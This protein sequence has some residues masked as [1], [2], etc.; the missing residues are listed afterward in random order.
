[1]T[2]R[3]FMDAAES[4]TPSQLLR[5]Q[6]A[7]EPLSLHARDCAACGLW[8]ES[9][10]NLGSA[11]HTLSASTEQRGAGPRVEQAVLQAFR[12]Q[13]FAPKVVAMPVRTP[14]GLW[15]LSRVLEFGAYAAVA[16]ALIVGLFLGAR[17]L[18]DKQNSS[19]TEQA[20]TTSAPQSK[21]QELT[22]AKVGGE[23][24]EQAAKPTKTTGHPSRG[25]DGE[26]GGGGRGQSNIGWQRSG[27]ICCADALRSADLLGRRAS[28]PHGVAR[29]SDRGREQCAASSG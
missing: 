6:P 18:R 25:R 29:D 27:R 22:A 4:F 24:K 3:E 19:R 12:T 16:A 17:I 21:P 11:L 26:A 2:C 28:R 15:K 23:G 14:P 13:G 20:Q 9:H 1:M 7:E 10:R 8:L 5:M